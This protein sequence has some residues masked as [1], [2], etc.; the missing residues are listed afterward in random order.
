MRLA[1]AL[2][3]LFAATALA[4]S[5]PEGLSLTARMNTKGPI[6]PGEAIDVAVKLRNSS[7]TLSHRVVRPGDGSECGWREPHVFWTATFAGPDGV[8]VPLEATSVGRCGLFAAEWWKEVV[9][10]PPH[11]AI[12]V[13]H[14][15]PPHRVFDVQGEG[16]LRL[17]AHYAWGG[18]RNSRADPMTGAG[19][20][21][22]DMGGMKGVE[23]YE[24]VSN[25]VEIEVR[26]AFDVILAPKAPAKKGIVAK[27]SDLVDARLRVRDAMKLEPREWTVSLVVAPPATCEMNE[28]VAPGALAKPAEIAAAATAPLVGVG[29]FAEGRDVRVRFAADGKTRV[30]AYVA[31]RDGEGVRI[32]SNWIELTVEP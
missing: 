19:G 9:V 25:A 22:P 26:P 13:E 21:P 6:Q 10:L 29:A 31:R 23:P 14:L 2:A 1:V 30:A 32:R 8:A 16:T 3:A 27:L 12:D 18:G 20:A 17:V 5:A 15:V 11:G 24:L 4:G 28:E 7:A